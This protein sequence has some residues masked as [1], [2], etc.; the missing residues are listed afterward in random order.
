[1]GVLTLRAE[2]GL[3]F[4]IEAILPMRDTLRTLIFGLL[5]F[6]W[7]MTRFPNKFR[8]LQ[9]KG[10]KRSTCIDFNVGAYL[11]CSPRGCGSFVNCRSRLSFVGV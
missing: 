2:A 9:K 1:M 4:S 3:D 10:Q 7:K 5:Q 8:S 6:V 11:E